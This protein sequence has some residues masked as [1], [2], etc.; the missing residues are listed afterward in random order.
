MSYARKGI[1]FIYYFGGA[2]EDYH[3]PGDSP[4]KIDY[5]KLEKVTRTIYLTLR[6][7]A[8]VPR[9]PRLDKHVPPE[10]FK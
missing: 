5:S 10:L 8:T 4:D 3:R 1:P 6:Q 7:L 2:H 9:R